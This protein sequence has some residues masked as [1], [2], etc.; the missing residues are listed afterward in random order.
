[1]NSLGIVE[2]MAELSSAMVEAARS[3][4]WPRLSELQQAHA[5]L[6]DR[7]AALEPAGRQAGDL[8]GAGGQRKARLIARMLEDDK[9]I[10]AEVEPWLASTRKLLFSNVRGREMRA[11]YGAMKP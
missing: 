11:A 9:A 5:R 8:D 1:M 4:D 6:R 2:S 3:N 10:R 7:L